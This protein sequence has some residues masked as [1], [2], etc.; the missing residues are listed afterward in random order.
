[1]FKFKKI[2][3]PLTLSLSL[4][5]SATVLSSPMEHRDH[6]MRQIL[7][8]LDLSQ[9]QRQDIRQLFKEGHADQQLFREDKHQFRQQLHSLIKRSDWD[10]AAV[11]SLLK[12]QQQQK[13]LLDLQRA[14]SKH[15]LWLLLSPEQ[16][17]KLS[18]LLAQNQPK[19]R[20]QAEGFTLLSK[21]ALSAEQRTQIAELENK[22]QQTRASQASVHQTFA[23]AE[24]ALLT[25]TEFDQAAWQSLQQTLHSEMLSS[26]VASAHTRNQIWNLLNDEQQQQMVELL[27][28]HKKDGH[29]RQGMDKGI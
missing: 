26:A 20:P 24:R 25:K 6:G 9:S 11:A 18:S 22:M 27:K 17:D 7:S 14:T 23:A 2:I 13:I 4:L 8:Q 1:M 19:E 12:S 15:K 28:E 29:K 5:L 16:Q 3:A 21:L 10:E